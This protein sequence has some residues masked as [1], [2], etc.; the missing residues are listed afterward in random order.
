M[1]QSA[2]AHPPTQRCAVLLMTFPNSGTTWL[3][4]M[5]SVATQLHAESLYSEG[6][7]TSWGTTFK[8]VFTNE[9]LR[10]RRAP[11]G[12]AG[13]C[14]FIKTHS[15]EELKNAQFLSRYRIKGAV[16]LL[17]DP[18]SNADANWRFWQKRADHE[19]PK[20]CRYGRDSLTARSVHYHDAW[21]CRLQATAAALS[22]PLLQISYEGM[23]VQPATVLRR[24]LDFGGYAFNHTGA[25]QAIASFPPSK[26]SSNRNN[27][28]G[29]GGTAFG[30]ALNGAATIHAFGEV[31][32]FGVV[33]IR[34][35]PVS[36]S[37]WSRLS[38]SLRPVLR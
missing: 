29:R 36:W 24:V 30:E 32:R 23:L 15:W 27:A 19:E 18:N 10:A 14:S 6:V 34:L 21:Y 28:I 20:P 9:D 8:N 33:R 13:S 12:Q 25:R 37:A 35:G 31:G 38:G 1:Q 3:Q 17:R 22:V 7:K 11:T 26:A 4:S 2:A 5:F 16:T